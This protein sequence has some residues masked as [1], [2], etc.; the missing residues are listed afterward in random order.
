METIDLFSAIREMRDITAAG[1]TFSFV[2]ASFNRDEQSTT[3]I[4]VVHKAYLR[5]A[6]HS[7]NVENAEHKLFYF[8]AEIRKPRVC[9]QPVIMFFNNKK[10][11]V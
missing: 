2:H 11:S 8:D 10:I 7:D 9:W 3:G 5:Q 4:R 6:A 1:G